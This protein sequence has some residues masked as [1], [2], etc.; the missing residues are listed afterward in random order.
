MQEQLPDSVRLLSECDSIAKS[1]LA[2]CFH[3]K[4]SP[5]GKALFSLTTSVRVRL[6]A[7]TIPGALSA[8]TPVLAL[9]HSSTTLKYLKEV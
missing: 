9:L 8:L 7:R 1:S 3:A 6:T 4:P 5:H 2:N